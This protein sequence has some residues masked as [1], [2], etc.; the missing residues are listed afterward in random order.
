MKQPNHHCTHHCVIGN[1]FSKAHDE[2]FIESYPV[3]KEQQKAE[4]KV[5]IYIAKA[6]ITMNEMYPTATAIAIQDKLIYAVGCLEDIETSLQLKNIAYEVN[7]D[8]KS[9][10]FYPG[11]IESHCHAS[12]EA[13]YHYFVYVGAYPRENAQGEFMPAL[14]SN[15]A[16]IEKLKLAALQQSDD[17]LIAW[18]YDPTLLRSDEPCLTAD[19]LDTVSKNKSVIVMNM[20]GHIAYAN[21]KAL[22]MMGYNDQSD[23]PGVVRKNGKLTGELQELSAMAPLLPK[24]FVSEERL[25]KGVQAFAEVAHRKGV[26]TAT[27][28]GLG[29]IP[30][31]WKAL[32]NATHISD[33]PIKISSYMMH[34]VCQSLGG[35]DAFY[36]A[37]ESENDKLKL[38]GVKIVSDGSIQGYTAYMLWPYYY[39]RAEEGLKNIELDAGVKLLQ[40]LVQHGIQVAIHTNGDAAIEGVL[41]CIEHVMRFTPDRDPRFRL[42]HCQTVNEKQLSKMN[43]YHVLANFFVNHIYYWGDFHKK[44]TLGPIRVHHLN[45]LASAKKHGITFAL[46][47]DAPITA[48]N[49]LRMIQTAVE[50]KS[51]SGEVL[52]ENERI[53]VYDALKAVT[54]DAA[55]LLR[56]EDKKG[57]LETGKLADITILERN[58]SEVPAH[59]IAEISVVATI[60]NGKVFPMGQ[61]P[62]T[63]SFT[64]E[65]KKP[66][67]TDIVDAE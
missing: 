50:R 52:G 56:E 12:M 41:D 8:F 61:K 6:I 23:Q 37:K 60:L 40:E 45:P 17:L 25:T 47:S 58:I 18:G 64:K 32:L 5:V 57:T 65:H 19:D 26:T 29:L 49:P 9:Q 38:N 4:G 22:E 43:K 34:Q 28:L 51:T 31:S 27:D 7:E 30:G 24:L 21:H 67:L 42:E 10:Y 33:F 2:S 1:I 11:F 63:E 46:H 39:D 15:Q 66:I 20:S 55:Y 59:Q 54:K 53:S 13:L 48:I 44:H 16:V 62:L 3:K 14:K 35:V 36:K